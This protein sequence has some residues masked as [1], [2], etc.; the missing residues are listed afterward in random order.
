MK[1][2]IS[3]LLSVLIIVCGFSF[4]GISAYAAYVGSIETTKK[5]FNAHVTVNGFDS[6]HGTYEI[7]E[8]ED[9]YARVEFVYDGE[10]PLEYWEIKDLQEGVDYV[11]LYQDGNKLIIGIIN[12]DVDYV[13]A[14]A[15]TKTTETT[16]QNETTTK[17]NTDN[18]SPDTG[19]LSGITLASASI[20]CGAILLCSAKKKK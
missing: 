4:T 13:E 12:K 20:A 1:K 18:K 5:E 8:D 6:I 17:A 19:A 10:D 7:V 15:V 3:V 11:I 2:I 14:N 9:Y 16:S